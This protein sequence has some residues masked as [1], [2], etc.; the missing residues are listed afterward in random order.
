M[1][2][3]YFDTSATYPLRESAYHAMVPWLQDIC[4]NSGSTHA[5]G[6]TAKNAL[7]QY[8]RVISELLGCFPDELVFTSGGTESCQLAVRGVMSALKPDQRWVSSSVAEHPAVTRT[9]KL[10]DYWQY[11]QL[12]IT[13]IAAPILNQI[14]HGGLLCVMAANNEV[15]TLSDLDLAKNAALQSSSL[16]FVDA[17]QTTGSIPIQLDQSGIDLMAASAHKFGGPLGIGL[18]YIRRGTSFVSPS[19]GGGQEAG[20]RSGTVN[21]PGIAGMTAALSE[22]L[23]DRESK[24]QRLTVMRNR[25]KDNLSQIDGLLITGAPINRLPGHI[26]CVLDG[27]SADIAL[28]A[29]DAVGICAGSGSACSS[30]LGIPSAV[31]MALGLTA[32]QALGALRFSYGDY[33]SDKQ[34]ECALTTIQGTLSRLATLR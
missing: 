30:G 12:D 25:L 29:L 13:S 24:N 15:G 26:S 17:V 33:L 22:S 11:H 23:C 19:T 2:R 21:L 32:T 1:E 27:V 18:L 7:E 8:R 20:R 10:C 6:Q 4:G 9:A 5:Y 28:A 34:F 3:F 31:H 14:P 16:L